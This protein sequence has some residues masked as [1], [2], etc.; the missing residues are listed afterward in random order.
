MLV[1]V[2]QPHANVV[3]WLTGNMFR[4]QSCLSRDSTLP[5]HAAYLEQ[6]LIYFTDERDSHNLDLLGQSSA[7]TPHS[8]LVLRSAAGRAI[9]V[10]T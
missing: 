8:S 5:Q 3:P 1:L 9:Q 2:T 6:G 10:Y 7:E 4:N